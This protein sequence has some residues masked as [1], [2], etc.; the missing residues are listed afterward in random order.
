MAKY[1][2]RGSEGDDAP[3]LG[4]LK[5]LGDGEYEAH[6]GESAHTLKQDIL[7]KNADISKFNIYKAPD[8]YLYLVRGKVPVPTYV[9][10]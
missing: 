9:K 1:E 6:T 8:G 3:N 5:K 10:W 4:D 2:Q 7:G